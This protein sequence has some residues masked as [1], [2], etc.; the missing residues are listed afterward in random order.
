[1]IGQRRRASFLR[2][3]ARTS[4]FSFSAAATICSAADGGSPGR[5]GGKFEANRPRA[6]G[7]DG[8]EI[9]ESVALYPDL[10][11]I[12]PDRSFDQIHA[13]PQLRP[14]VCGP[15][16]GPQIPSMIAEGKLRAKRSNGLRLRHRRRAE[17]G[18]GE[19]RP[20]RAERK[21]HYQHE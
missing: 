17:R 18:L 7:L 4:T 10:E 1:M 15:T 11:R 9:S 14:F 21:A 2:A 8:G 3:K 12:D 20:A 5:I 13:A 19:A 16:L 6:A